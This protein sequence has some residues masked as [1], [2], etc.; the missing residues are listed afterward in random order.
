MTILPRT[1]MGSGRPPAEEQLRIILH[2]W[3]DPG[4]TP[5]MRHSPREELLGQGSASEWVHLVRA[6]LVKLVHHHEDGRATILGLRGRGS[7]LGACAALAGG[8]HP[9]SAIA[10]TACETHR[11]AIREFLQSVREVPA[12]SW[13]VHAA[14]C[15]EL[16]Q[17]MMQLAAL[18]CLTARERLEEFLAILSEELDWDPAQAGNG[19]ELPVRDWELAQLLAITPPYLSK[20]MTELRAS[21]RLTRHG[22]RGRYLRA[23][24]GP[25]SGQRGEG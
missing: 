5:T 22:K 12:V 9:Y 25:P 19:V 20:L 18:A 10:V 4:R 2:R 17:Q 1:A 21:G 23:S 3:G 7:L 24:G 13:A 6:G 8:L 15:D 14:H 11:I 16:Q